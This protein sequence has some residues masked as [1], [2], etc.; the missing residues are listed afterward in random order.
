MLTAGSRV[1]PKTSKRLEA[2]LQ[3]TID[4][5]TA[6][7]VALEAGGGGGGVTDHGALT[8]LADD[9]HP[10]YLTD[11][12]GDA[13]YAPAAHTHA[14]AGVIGFVFDG[15]G[16]ALVVG[17]KCRITVPFACTI[18][19][20]RMLADQAGSVVVDIW[21]DTYA[22]YPA[23]IADTIVA[24]AKPTI[25]AAAKSE[26]TTLTGWTL[27]VAAGDTLIANIDSCSA[28]TQLLVQLKVTR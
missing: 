14:I 5:L 13:Q 1:R 8:G 16:T 26:D 7:V 10:Q 18:T 6:R 2:Q 9:D 28:I 4:A 17:S 12:E 24:A 3:A 21:K 23:T 27:S 25:S 22:N 20:N 15:N 11:P 19:A